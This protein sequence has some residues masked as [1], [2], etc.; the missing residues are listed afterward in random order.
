MC[1][2]VRLAH[3]WNRIKLWQPPPHPHS[4]RELE[5]RILSL[6]S[7]A[8]HL[9]RVSRIITSVATDVVDMSTWSAAKAQSAETA[10]GGS[11]AKSC[12]HLSQLLWSHD[13]PSPES[14]AFPTGAESSSRHT[15]ET[16]EEH[17]TA[18]EHPG[19]IDE[20][21][22]VRGIWATSEE[23]AESCQVLLSA[24]APASPPA[25]APPTACA[26]AKGTIF[27]LHYSPPV[28]APLQQ[29]ALAFAVGGWVGGWVGGSFPFRTNA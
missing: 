17:H 12:E 15:A 9:Q 4:M 18:E 22:D 7:Q 14:W 24:L 20:D 11:A 10:S 26:S 27:Y 28:D 29:S 13:P 2:S 6:L 1:R 8:D 19:A 21:N 25:G 3:V 23:H 16:H 5:E